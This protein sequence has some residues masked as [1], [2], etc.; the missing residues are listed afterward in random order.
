MEYDSQV[1]TLS[2]RTQELLRAPEFP[3]S[4]LRTRQAATL[5]AV[6]LWTL[7]VIAALLVVSPMQPGAHLDSIV[8]I[9]TP[10]IL[11]HV[12]CFGL[13]RT[14]RVRLSATVYTLTL[15][16][17]VTGIIAMFGGMTGQ[18][19]SVYIFVV[20]LAAFT[21]GAGW[22]LFFAGISGVS[23]A[24]FVIIDDLLPPPIVE[25]GPF[26]S[27]LALTASLI[28]CAL[29]TYLAL[30]NLHLVLARAEHESKAR[31]HTVLELQD[32]TTRIADGAA[33][34]DAVADLGLAIL[35]VRGERE[36]CERA[37][38]ALVKSDEVL[39]AAVLH[40]G[41][42]ASVL[43]GDGWTPPDR[44]LP[45]VTGSAAVVWDDGQAFGGDDAD[46]I[47]CSVPG[48]GSRNAVLAAI[49]REAS[50]PLVAFVEGVSRLLATALAREDLDE[51]V[52]R[53]GRLEALGQLAGGVAHDFNNL[54]VV[55]NGGVQLIDA[56]LSSERD[57]LAPIVQDM[58]T[59]GERAADLTR[60]LLAFA[61]PV[62]EHEATVRPSEVIDELQQLL[63]RLIDQRVSLL[64]EVDDGLPPIQASRTELHQV[65]L[66]L[67][68]NARDAMDGEGVLTIRARRWANGEGAPGVRMDI[69]D[70]G[71][72]LDEET[73]RRMF[74]PFFT[75]KPKG[76]GTGLGLAL[77]WGVLTGAGGTVRVHSRQGEGTSFELWWPEAHAFVEEVDDPDSVGDALGGLVL[78]VDDDVQVRRTVARF[79]TR[80]GC[81]VVEAGSGIEALEVM[82][83]RRPDLVLTD[84]SMPHLDGPGLAARLRHSHPDLPVVFMTGY[85]DDDQVLD[86][87]TL[88]K[89]FSP[90][91]L[92]S[93]LHRSLS[94]A[95]A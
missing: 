6:L 69:E 5:R 77:V 50:P 20:M 35:E 71:S 18:S 85:A 36:L 78:L 59:A 40:V 8:V 94:A 33:R 74:E 53:F 29:V 57:D 95:R 16:V 92:S 47:L 43:A 7:A 88:S 79:I 70:T 23:I 64:V 60:Q 75:T 2:E 25:Q 80:A 49:V 28:G 68:I 86:G 26:D 81:A 30:R 93:L 4:P 34:S 13:L 3:G 55:I 14:G 22:G 10:V 46:M 83:S 45:P 84:V 1:A 61:R 56:E 91:A 54:L 38:A 24:T 72:G 63:G 82:R 39:G 66:N 21:L 87:P 65:L 12:V 27:A 90:Q 51:R 17:V 44:E 76:Q 73:R 15:W 11:L 41:E 32:A 31:A 9:Y 52:E 42:G 48:R 19:A 37:V 67:C 62:A 58:R 89:P